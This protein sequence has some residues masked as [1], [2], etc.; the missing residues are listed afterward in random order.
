LKEYAKASIGD[1]VDIESEKRKTKLIV[2]TK[3]KYEAYTG[4]SLEMKR[5]LDIVSRIGF[6]IKKKNQESCTLE[7][8]QERTDIESEADIIEEVL[9][10]EGYGQ[11]LSQAPKIALTPGVESDLVVTKEKARDM[12]EG[13]GLHEIYSYTFLGEKDK[14]ILGIDCV[15]LANPMS[16]EIKYIRPSLERGVTKALEEGMKYGDEGKL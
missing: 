11:I 3:K 1:I 4:A 8:P 6:I 10:F 15:E 14:D 12:L 13:F 7:I 16:N 9:R 5:A 2:F